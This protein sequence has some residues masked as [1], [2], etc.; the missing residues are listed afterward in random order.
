MLEAIKTVF[1]PQESQKVIDPLKQLGNREIEILKENG[2]DL[3]FLKQVLPQGGLQ[4]DEEYVTYGNGYSRCVTVYSYTKDPTLFWLANLMNNPHTIATLDI[5]TD[6][7]QKIINNINR[8]LDELDDRTENERKATD[9]NKSAQEYMELAEYAQSLTSNGEISKQIKV[10]IY[11]YGNT[12]EEV[13]E[14]AQELIENLKGMDYHAVTYLHK[15]KRD[16]QALFTLFNEQEEWFGNIRGQSLPS[17]NIGGGFPFHH[18]T[19]K[20]PGGTHYGETMTGGAFV[21]NATYKNSVR[22]STNT[23]LL[24]MMGA[25][26]STVLKMITET[27]LA[28]GDSIWGFEKGKDFIPLLNEYNGTIVRLDGSDGMINPLEIFATRT[29]DEAAEKKRN[30]EESNELIINEEASYRAHLD[31]VVYQVELVSPHMKGTMKSEFRTYLSE[32]YEAYGTVPKGFGTSKV[33]NEQS[34]K[35][36]TGLEPEAYP[37]FS[38][39]LSYLKQL[40]LPYASQEKKNR[41][42]AIESIVEDLCKTYG[43]IFDGHS[44]IEHLNTKQFVFFDIDSIDGLDRGVQQC[45]MYLAMTLIWNQALLQGRKQRRLIKEG[46]LKEED[47][48]RFLAVID[49]CHNVINPNF[50]ETVNYVTNFQREMRKVEAMTVLATQSPQEMVPENMTSDKFSELKKVFE[51][52]ST[53]IFMRMDESIL[54]HIER[55]VGNS[56]TNSELESIPQQNQG[57][58]VIA[59]GS[60]ESI[61]VH[62]TPNQRQLKLFDGGK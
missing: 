53:K 25:G 7:K 3:D 54:R 4:F 5:K 44:T 46:K 11:V 23:L 47:F 14:R 55:L 40:D 26:K 49:E 60:K 24:G 37:T 61:R 12:L 57:D 58:A 41:K 15:T 42:E 21:W 17:N 13:D 35:K 30:S 1:S 56:M 20:D 16:W 38:D 18:Q 51:F 28:K 8:A 31:K 39:F 2:Y 34:Q 29:Y 50:I 10:R 62:F 32:F 9:R 19:L 22:L 27:H 52:S 48:Q 45:Q 43:M 36:V 33:R 6:E 59:F